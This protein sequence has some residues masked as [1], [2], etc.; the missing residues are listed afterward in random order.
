MVKNYQ[1]EKKNL[2]LPISSFWL[3]NCF[4]VFSDPQT[5]N[6]IITKEQVQIF[7]FLR[8]YYEKL[9]TYRKFERIL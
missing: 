9:Q 6:T 8:I 1:M 5:V 4:S 7:Y 3:T 2:N